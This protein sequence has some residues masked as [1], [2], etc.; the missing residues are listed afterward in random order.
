MFVSKACFLH[1]IR[2]G[3]K[4]SRLFALKKISRRL[5]AEPKQE[6]QFEREK[7][8]LDLAQSR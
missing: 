6:K 3:C 8:V 2:N 4:R 1:Y 7:K 5:F